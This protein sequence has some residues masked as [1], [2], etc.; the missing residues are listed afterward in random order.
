MDDLQQQFEQAQQAVKTLTECPDNATLLKL[1]V[2]YKQATEGN[3]ADER[4]RMSEFVA[5]AKFDAWEALAGTS[6]DDA[7]N[8]YISLVNGLMTQAQA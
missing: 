3:A 8:Q 4:P 6:E 1:Y 7:M 2:T 5:R